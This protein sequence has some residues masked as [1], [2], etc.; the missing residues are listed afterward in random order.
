M[1]PVNLPCALDEKVR[2][3]EGRLRCALPNHGPSDAN[4]KKRRAER[5]RQRKARR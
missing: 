2:D 3:L 1:E 4:R 5:A